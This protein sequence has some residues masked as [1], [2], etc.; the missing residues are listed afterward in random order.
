MPHHEL[1]EET[2]VQ[3]IEDYVR[4]AMAGVVA[5]DFKHVDRV[6][7]WALLI[8]QREGFEDSLS[9]EIAALLHDIG[10]PHLDEENERSKHGQVGA[11]MARSF[12]K[13]DSALT[14]DQIERITLAI[15]Y[16][17]SPPS[18]VAEVI[19][20]VGEK[21]RLLEIIRDADTMDALGAVGLMRAFTSKAATR[22]YSPGNVRG[23]TWGLSSG[24]FDERF[25]MGQGIGETII[26]QVNFQASIYDNLK[27]ETARR[28]AKPLVEYMKEFVA[29]LESE[30]T[31]RH[32]E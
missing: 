4:L 5:H 18:V 29:R 20:T 25:A 3:R 22:E 27:T 6:R 13:Q 7:R 8:A 24:G 15:R 11:E 28:L 30:I 14:T 32:Q 23:D 21:G 26:D 31:S 10:L 9:V 16:H 1:K 17:G 19:G 2:R 12:L